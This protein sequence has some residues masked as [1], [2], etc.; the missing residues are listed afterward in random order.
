MNA[1]CAPWISPSTNRWLRFQCVHGIGHGLTMF[2]AHNSA[3][4]V[5]G[6]DLLRE[7]WD[8]ESCYGGAFMENI[9]NATASHH[10]PAASLHV[11]PAAATHGGSSA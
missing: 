9:V 5:G 8:R 6:C 4:G 7:H 2:Y 10:H 3:A 11:G 1:M